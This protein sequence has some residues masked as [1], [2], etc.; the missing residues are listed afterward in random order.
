MMQTDNKQRLGLWHT[1]ALH[2]E[3]RGRG[4]RS[5]GPEHKPQQGKD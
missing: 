2:Q 4:V 3:G 5:N 1:A